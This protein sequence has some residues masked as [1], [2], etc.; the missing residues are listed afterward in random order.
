M[1]FLV[2]LYTSQDLAQNVVQTHGHMCVPFRN[3]VENIASLTCFVFKGP[4][5]ERITDIFGINDL[6][7][8]NKFVLVN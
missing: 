5:F 6:R 7:L 3:S 4:D 8:G 2:M 1:N